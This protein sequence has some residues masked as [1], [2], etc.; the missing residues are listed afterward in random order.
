MEASSSSQQFNQTRRQT[1]HTT[2]LCTPHPSLPAIQHSKHHLSSSTPP[3][4]PTSAIRSAPLP[5][6]AATAHGH[7]SLQDAQ[8]LPGCRQGPWF[9][10]HN[11]TVTTAL[12]ARPRSTS[13]WRSSGEGAE[14]KN[15]DQG[16]RRG[17]S[18]HGMAYQGRIDRFFYPPPSDSYSRCTPPE[19]DRATSKQGSR[20]RGLH[21]L[22]LQIFHP[23]SP[24]AG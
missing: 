2:I 24:P 5:L 6:L 19:M 4:T 17:R 7:L 8:S 3:K 14:L 16:Q 13:G 18:G 15:V 11:S 9:G 20:R 21:S 1:P 12:R 22:P 10:T 23:D